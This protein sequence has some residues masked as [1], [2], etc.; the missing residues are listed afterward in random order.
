MGGAQGRAYVIDDG[1]TSSWSFGA[2]LLPLTLFPSTDESEKCPLREFLIKFSVLNEQR[3]LTLDFKTFCSITGLDYY[4]GKYV[5]H[6]KPEGPKA[7]GALFKKRKKPKSKKPPTETKVTPPKPTKCSEQSHSVSSGTVPDPQDLERDIQL[8]RGNKQPLDRDITSMTPDEGTAKTTLRSEGSL[9]D[10]DS[11]GN[12]P[13]ADMEPLHNPVANPSGTV[14]LLSDDELDKEI[15]EEEVLVARDYMDEDPQ[16]DAA[17][18]TP[19]PDPTQ[20]EPSHVQESSFDSSS[21]D[22][23]KFDNTFPLTKRQLIKYHRKMSKASNDQYYDENIAH[24]DQTDKLVEASMSSLDRSSTTIS[25]L[26]KGLDVITQ[27]LKNI[28]NGVKDDPAI[29]QKLNEATKTF[30]RISSNITET[31]LKSE[32]SP[33]RQDTLEIKSMM[34]EIYHAFKGQPSST[35]LGSITP[36]LALTHIPANVEG[37]NATNT[38]TEEPLLILRGRLEKQQWQ[39]QYHQFIL[40]KIDKGKGITTESYED[41]SKRL[42]PASTIIRPDPDEPVRDEY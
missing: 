40:L 31:A 12:I 18:R 32:V 30:T 17:V 25:D 11:G 8:A 34:V 16:D 42:V 35:P 14:F 27:L 41:S 20:P 2:L 6:H 9:R 10:K 3:P 24:R 23:K 19:S 22:L 21:P 29:Y 5:A 28:N 36:T 15:D 26:Y 1:I 37:E 4:N 13:P 39:F 7:S 38:A 33:L